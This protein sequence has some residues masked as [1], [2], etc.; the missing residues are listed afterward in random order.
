MAN[1]VEE[2]TRRTDD[3]LRQTAGPAEAEKFNW[4]QES[5][6]IQS[7]QHSETGKHVHVDSKGQFYNQDRQPVEAAQAVQHATTNAP[8]VQQ[9]QQFSRPTPAQEYTQ[10]QQSIGL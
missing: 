7:Y 1:Q 3:Y 8:A 4:K 10:P 9:E 2:N 5:G 6:D